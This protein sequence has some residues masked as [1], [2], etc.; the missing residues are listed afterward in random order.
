MFIIQAL[1]S[2]HFVQQS[3]CPIVEL[4]LRMKKKKNEETNLQCADVIFTEKYLLHLNQ[5]EQI[6]E[7]FNRFMYPIKL[8]KKD[9]SST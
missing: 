5:K 2:I 6:I 8:N 9:T 3:F 4:T 1:K 7:L